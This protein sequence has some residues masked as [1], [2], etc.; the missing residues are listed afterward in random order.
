VSALARAIDDVRRQLRANPRLQIASALIAALVGTYG[1]LGL[2]DLRARVADSYADRVGE[3]RALRTLARQ[4]EWLERAQ[5]AARLRK[6][7]E[8]QIGHATTVGIAEAEVQAWARERAA[9]TGGQIQIAPQATVEVEAQ[10]G[11]WRVP[12]VMSG[13]AEPMQVVQLMQTIETSA[14]LAVV[15]QASLLNRENRTFSVTVVFYY[16]IDGAADAAP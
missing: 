12:V 9:A 10:P 3:M 1:L 4:P 7:L 16:R 8:A 13:A 11:L 15:E 2:V 14:R 5:A 6:G